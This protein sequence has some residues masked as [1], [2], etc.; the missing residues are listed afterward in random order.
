MAY[1]DNA[2]IARRYRADRGMTRRL[3]WFS[4]WPVVR[5]RLRGFCSG[6]A[7]DV[8]LVGLEDEIGAS[9]PVSD[10]PP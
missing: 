2:R 3:V 6:L 9:L 5:E 1:L 8:E 7:P 10:E 4:G